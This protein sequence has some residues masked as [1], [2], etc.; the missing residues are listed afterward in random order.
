MVALA[1][2]YP[3]RQCV[4]I[5]ADRTWGYRSRQELNT[6][7]ADIRSK[8]ASQTEQVRRLEAERADLIRLNQRLQDELHEMERQAHEHRP[9]LS[10]AC[11]FILL[12]QLPQEGRQRRSQRSATWSSTTAGRQPTP[13]L[14]RIAAAHRRTGRAFSTTTTSTPT[15]RFPRRSRWT[16]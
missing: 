2:R 12:E 11:A 15:G 9:R 13:H 4:Y 6:A 14:E 7:L 8:Q 16:R 10:A 1:G 3:P 5:G